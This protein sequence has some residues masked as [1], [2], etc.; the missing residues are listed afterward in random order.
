MSEYVRFSPLDSIAGTKFSQSR[1]EGQLILTHRGALDLV[2][3]FRVMNSIADPEG[4]ETAYS[5]LFPLFRD[6]GFDIEFETM[7]GMA[8]VHVPGDAEMIDHPSVPEQIQRALRESK[9]GVGDPRLMLDRALEEA[10]GDANRNVYY[11]KLAQAYASIGDFEKAFHTLDRVRSDGV[12]WA[13]RTK[14]ERESLEF[15]AVQL[16]KYERY[17]EAIKYA[18]QAN[19]S[20]YLIGEL[21]VY[22]AANQKNAADANYYLTIAESYAEEEADPLAKAILYS[23]IGGVR[24][25]HGFDPT[26]TFE[27]VRDLLDGIQDPRARSFGYTALGRDLSTI[28]SFDAQRA[29][30]KAIGAAEKIAEYYHHDT[31]ALINQVD[32]WKE[33]AESLIE[34]GYYQG[35]RYVGQI[36]GSNGYPIEQAVLLATLGI[37]ELKRGLSDK[38]IQELSSNHV[39]LMAQRRVGP[40]TDALNHFGLLE[41]FG[42]SLPVD[43][44]PSDQQD[45]L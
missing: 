39:R 38:S 37:E 1:L 11:G 18:V 27:T 7:G 41:K 29:F 6:V 17:D 34:F 5:L 36:L 3:S 4:K 15:I 21:F 43:Q 26:R 8:S 40:L 25:M 30:E 28:K 23:F 20:R 31:S 14:I 45:F 9:K 33:I 2:E 13:R 32:A 10:E 44:T 12:L 19:A 42:L 35:A 16:F 24:T 22:R